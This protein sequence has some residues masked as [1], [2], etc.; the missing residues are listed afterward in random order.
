MNR[1]GVIKVK[2]LIN[3]ADEN[4]KKTQ[5]FNSWTGKKIAKF[6]K[7]YSF[8]PQDIEKEFYRENSKILNETRGNGLWLWKPY[9]IYKV[10]SESKDG[11]IIFY[12]DS[13]SFF[14]RNIEEL[15]K[16]M[17]I[18]ES[19]WVSDIPLL[20]SCFTK[21]ECF[22]VMECNVN[23]I[24][25]SNQ[26]QATFLMIKSCEES[27]RFIKE[28]LDLCMNYELLCPK[29]NLQ[30]SEKKGDNFIVHR[31][32]Q[33]ILSLLC[34][35]NNIKPHLDPSQRGKFQESY[36]NEN[37]TFKKTVHKD[38]YRPILFLHK[39]PSVKIVGCL[40]ILVKM[41]ISKIKYNLNYKNI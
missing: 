17:R 30:C 1:L 38:T 36:Y 13:G 25:Y 28:W 14:I 41:T 20:E 37:Y 32:D 24:K 40:K 27:K 9:F 6:D 5:R 3:Y 19:I 34:K 21:P 16:S 26:I 8:G 12:C 22:E 7:V 31:E 2:I 39:S 15:I 35:K 11:D 33:S 29:G 23:K 10:L 4:Y 18:D